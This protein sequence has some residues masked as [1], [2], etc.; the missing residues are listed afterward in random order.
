[1]IVPSSTRSSCNLVMKLVTFLL[2]VLGVLHSQWLCSNA[3]TPVGE[4]PPI[5]SVASYRPVTSTSVC[6]VNNAEDF[7]RY[8]RDTV[9]S[10]APNCMR[11]TCNNTC[12]FSSTSP[13]AT[14]IAVLGT[15]GSGV[16]TTEGRPDSSTG[17]L[18]FQNSF[19]SVP[20]AQVPTVGDHGFSFVAWI[21]QEADNVGY[22]E[23][24]GCCEC[25]GEGGCCCCCWGWGL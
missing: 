8:T 3:Q 12:P 20:G 4:Y 2:L 6:G 15:R 22:A 5:R 7:C 14:R 17:A 25:C 13:S 10:L 21:N 23:L 1:M 24:C 16:S 18:Q 19:I 9:A 11:E